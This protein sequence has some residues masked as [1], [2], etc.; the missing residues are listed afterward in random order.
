MG[1][2]IDLT[3]PLSAEDR[4]WLEERG[5]VGDLRVADEMFPDSV[6][7]DADPDDDGSMEDESESAYADWTKAQ[8][9]YEL[10]TRDLPASGTKA[11]LVERLEADDEAKAAEAQAA[12]D[13][14]ANAQS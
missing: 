8:M 1:R 11:E 2:E 10:S 3:Q 4:A 7:A 13:D 6:P 5:K 9:Q 14:A 12:E